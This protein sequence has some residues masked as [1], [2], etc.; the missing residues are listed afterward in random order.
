[1]DGNGKVVLVCD[2]ETMIADLLAKLL[3][4]EDYEPLL[5][6]C[7]KEAVALLKSKKVDM[8]V[9][10]FHLPDSNGPELIKMLH[11]VV[12]TLPI[13]M[14]SGDL[15]MDDAKAQAMGALAFCDKIADTDRLIG[16]INRQLKGG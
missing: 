11:E 4:L 14:L 3:E 7:A 8:A 15:G 13:V 5:S 16:I 6:Y 2:D 1:M 9:V 10:D 12:P